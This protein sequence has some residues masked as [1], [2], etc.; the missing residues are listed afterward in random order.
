MDELQCAKFE[1]KNLIHA[2]FHTSFDERLDLELYFF[3]SNSRKKATLTLNTACLKRGIYPADV[4][5][6]QISVSVDG[7]QI[8]SN[9]KLTAEIA[10]AVKDLR[11][12]FFSIL[13][14]CRSTSQLLSRQGKK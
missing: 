10:A 2:R 6:C 9:E 13:R 8:S 14:L 4:A 7:S 12:G 3:D 11:V 1:L 5:A